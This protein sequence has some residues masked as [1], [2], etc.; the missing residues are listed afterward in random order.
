MFM[1]L[2]E[3]ATLGPRSVR[4]VSLGNREHFPKAALLSRF[5]RHARSACLTPFHLAM[6]PALGPGNCDPR[7]RIARELD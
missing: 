7:V 4:G 1:S 6:N 3:A 5:W 2:Q